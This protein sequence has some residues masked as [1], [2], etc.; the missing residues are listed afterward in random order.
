MW[1]W[2][3]LT[4]LLTDSTLLQQMGEA[5]QKPFHCS[6]SF[7]SRKSPAENSCSNCTSSFPVFK[8]QD[9]D[10]TAIRQPGTSQN[11]SETCSYES[12]S[13][14]KNDL[15]LNSFSNCTPTFLESLLQNRFIL[16]KHSS[17]KS[18]WYRSF[19][20]WTT[21]ATELCM[22]QGNSYDDWL[23]NYLKPQ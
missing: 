9:T 2:Q 6:F 12:Q 22:P 21:L 5:L 16:K 4:R 3:L 20:N 10:S 8:Q 7:A 19:N 18:W 11:R 17:C 14:I 13:K 23:L 1:K 15:T